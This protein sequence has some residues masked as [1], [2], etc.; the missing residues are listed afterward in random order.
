VR[1]TQMID[2]DQGGYILPAF[3]DSLDAH[4]TKL[5]GYGP[6]RLGQPLDDFGFA[7]FAFTG[8]CPPPREA[9]PVTITSALITGSRH[10]PGGPHARRIACSD[11]KP[12]ALG[13]CG[14]LPGTAG[15]LGHLRQQRELP[16]FPRPRPASE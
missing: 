11:R 5:T 4:S 12:A 14:D 16:H 9:C 1:D 10:V 2:F 8:A 13:A 15:N 3:I 6:S 7:R